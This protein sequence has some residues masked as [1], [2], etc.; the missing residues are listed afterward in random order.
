MVNESTIKGAKLNFG[1]IGCGWVARDYVAPAIIESRNA[2]IVA[3]CDLNVENLSKIAPEKA[4]VFRTTNLKEF[5]ANPSMQAV[6]IA[7]PNDSHRF[8]TEKC[9]EAGKHVLCEKPMA[10]N[11]ADALRMVEV[12]ERFK[13][14]YATAFD[15]RFQAR[16]LR[17]RE[18]I[19]SGEAG[20]IT[21]AKIHYACWLPENWCEN[22]WRVDAEKAGGG[23][24][25]DLAPHGIDLLQYLLNDEIID[26]TAY[27]QS[28]IHSYKVDDGAVAIGRFK[29][30]AL[31][32][33]NVA[34]NCPD[35]F[36]RRTL[37]IIGTKKMIVAKNTMGQTSGGNLYLI[38]NKGE[39]LEVLIDESDDVSPFR[40]Q[41][42]T[43][44][45]CILNEKPFPFSPERDLQT[46][47][48]LFETIDK[49]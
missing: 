23:A 7:T 30:G 32:T 25:I 28:R 29:G 36:P 27:F 45:D 11:Y 22:N 18:I 16:H 31:L 40:L 19:E 42:E 10:T 13:V 35:E 41:I 21:V 48:I 1:I 12:C 9:A 34:Y 14:Q 47:R 8:L 46:M 2:E 39:T 17:L 6:Y 44:S 38:D 20:E 33:M 4:N 43:F 37:E 15:Q 3:L 24:F 26:F 49:Q 5:L